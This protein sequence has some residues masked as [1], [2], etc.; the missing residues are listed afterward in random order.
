MSSGQDV[1]FVLGTGSVENEDA[2]AVLDAYFAAGGRYLDTARVYGR[3]EA[4]VGSWLA[5]RGVRGDVV[6]LVKG[7]H[8]DSRWRPR[9]SR[10]AVFD[11]ARASLDD[12]GV[13]SVDSYLLHRDDPGQPVDAIAAVLTELV[14]SGIARAVGVSNWSSERVEL[15]LDALARNGGPPVSWVSNYFGL[16]T[17]A[18]PSPYPGVR[19]AV[20]SL[21]DLAR[22]SGFPVLAWSGLSSGYFDGRRAA[23]FESAA[24]AARRDVLR[25]VA[26]RHGASPTAVLARWMSTRPAIVAVFGSADA[27][28]VV[29]LIS[30]ARD[31]RLDDPVA[32][33]VSTLGEAMD[34]IGDFPPGA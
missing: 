11:D 15:L 20:P 2:Y 7:G 4:V 3:A 8:P 27:D 19:S 26:E 33:L 14:E 9:L 17:V 1:P 30:A 13:D 12:L 18:A 21:V 34:D 6:L 28:H 23:I 25:S 32:D 22:R 10:A 16:A 31:P 5:D 24:N 29:E